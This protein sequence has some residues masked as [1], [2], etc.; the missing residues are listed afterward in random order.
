MDVESRRRKK[1]P[2]HLKRRVETLHNTD[3]S[4]KN[5]YNKVTKI[6]EDAKIKKPETLSNLLEEPKQKLTAL[7]DTLRRYQIRSQRYQENNLFQ[8]DQKKFYRSFTWEQVE[9]GSTL[10]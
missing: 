8:T 5:F 2:S 9:Q 7:S 6:A 4:T 10:E 1:T 3:R